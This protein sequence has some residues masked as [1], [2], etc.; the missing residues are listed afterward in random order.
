MNTPQ[1][2]ALDHRTFLQQYLLAC[3]AAGKQE[4]IVHAQNVWDQI[5]A[6]VAEE[7]KLRRER[8]FEVPAPTTG[9]WSQTEPSGYVAK[10]PATGEPRATPEVGT[11]SSTHPAGECLCVPGGAYYW[12]EANSSFMCCACLKRISALAG[13]PRPTPMSK[14]P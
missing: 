9:G 8:D 6:V 14:R 1:P 5:E 7:A 4:S 11:I 2:T 13:V 10:F 3:A 12:S